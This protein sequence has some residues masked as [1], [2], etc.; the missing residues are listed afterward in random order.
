MA[1]TIFKVL[2]TVMLESVEHLEHVLLLPREAKV[3]NPHPFHPLRA[4]CGRHPISPNGENCTSSRNAKLYGRH[5]FIR[6]RN[7]HMAASQDTPCCVSVT[8]A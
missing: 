2:S 4:R 5:E 7:E 1:G 6:R 3:S 8:E